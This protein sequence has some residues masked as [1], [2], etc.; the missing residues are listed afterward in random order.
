[1]DFDD[2]RKK[3]TEIVTVGQELDDFS[4]AELQARVELLRAEIVR[5]EAEM[6]NKKST[7]TQAESVFKI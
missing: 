3:T 6:V 5:V 4:V 7:K 1:M 2:V